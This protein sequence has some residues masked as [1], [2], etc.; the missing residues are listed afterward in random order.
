MRLT[1]SR[2]YRNKGRYLL[3]AA[4]L[5]GGASIWLTRQTMTTAPTVHT[6]SGR[7]PG[8]P[9]P[10]TGA[11]TT[12]GQTCLNAPAGSEAP[13][14]P[15]RLTGRLGLYVAVVDPV[16]L[17]TLRVV[18]HDAGGLYPLASSYKQAV[19]WALLRQKD[20]GTLQL[21]ETFDV[22]SRTQSL[23]NYPYDH[24]DVL[25][26]AGRMIHN[27]D[28][29]ATDLLHR[30]VGLQAVQDVADGLGLCQT[31]LILPTKDWWTAQAGLSPHYP[32]AVSFSAMRGQVRLQAAQA[33]DADATSVR[34]D[35]L[36]RRLDSYFDHRYDPLTD[37]GTQNVSTP[38][39]FAHLVAAEFLNSGLSPAAQEVQ[40]RVMATG[41]GRSRIAAP[42]TYF[43][44]KGGNGWRLLAFSGYLHTRGGEDVVY[45]FMQ[46]GADQQ[47]TMPNMPA[48]FH[49]INDAMKSVLLVTDGGRV[50]SGTQASVP[51]APTAP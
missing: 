19:L 4:A 47:Y 14:P 39:E 7:A 29:T 38:A 11:T 42:L 1:A 28:N 20:T 24:S 9:A 48:A 30:R 51:P 17:T 10:L 18:S 40:R 44:G 23:G 37:L 32:G 34:P 45:A 15:K 16:T 21:S 22:T 5:L 13:P 27:S 46:H 3:L 6:V 36:Q 50:H 35:L 8:Q 33:V 26:L 25:T 12:G 49:W 31:R 41:F 43:G 2:R